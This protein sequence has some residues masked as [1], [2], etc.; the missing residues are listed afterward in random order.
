MQ[1]HQLRSHSVVVRK[2][3]E[4]HCATF[5]VKRITGE[6]L[7]LIYN[8]AGRSGKN[9]VPKVPN[10][11]VDFITACITENNKQMSI[12]SSVVSKEP[13]FKHKTL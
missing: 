3:N 7:R 12:L 8:L 5:L 2:L 1:I 6:N 13:G 11:F 10:I 4:G 9:I